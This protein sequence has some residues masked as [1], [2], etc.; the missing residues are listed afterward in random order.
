MDGIRSKD[1]GRVR[2]GRLRGPTVLGLI[3]LALIAVAVAAGGSTPTGRAGEARA[4]HLLIDVVASTA[5]IL[6]V[7]G[8][9]LWGW[10]LFARGEAIGQGAL[11][12]PRRSRV[13]VLAGLI[14][15]IVIIA[16]AVALR[17]ARD[18]RVGINPFGGLI[19]PGV[20]GGGS[21][22]YEPS[23]ATFPF[24]LTLVLL[25]VAV[26]GWILATRAR[27]RL[28]AGEQPSLRLVLADVLSE[29]L[30]DLRAE[31]DPRRAVVASYARMERALAAFGVPR[32]PA[33]SQDEFTR[34]VA[35]AADLDDAAVLRLT[36]L[37]S[38]ARYSGQDV[39]ATMKGEAIETLADLRDDLR[40]RDAEATAAARLAAA[41]AH[42]VRQRPT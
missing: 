34:R 40:R 8:A 42:T 9:A 15:L 14:V 7:V 29:T 36:A 11:E 18:G 22:G 26:T 37:F 10:L 13:A 25:V 31:P 20:G 38:W 24:V 4:S 39:P 21:G 35:T 30:D 19:E 2:S 17:R 1:A 23:F 28:D 41:A 3:G 27:G 6:I 33:E 32:A 5:L 12:R 16:V